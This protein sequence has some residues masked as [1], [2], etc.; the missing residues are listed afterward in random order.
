M[1]EA[2]VAKR[3]Y[4]FVCI[5]RGHLLLLLCECTYVYLHNIPLADVSISLSLTL[6]RQRM[7][8]FVYRRF[9]QHNRD[10]RRF[11]NDKT[12]LWTAWSQAFCKYYFS[13]EN[14]P[15]TQNI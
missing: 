5:L 11:T 15:R 8:M 2:Q 12:I 14:T 7:K 10:C 9:F 1:S 4:F 6:F 13:V 3:S